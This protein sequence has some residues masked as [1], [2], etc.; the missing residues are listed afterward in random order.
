MDRPI[1]KTSGK[2]AF[3]DWFDFDKLRYFFKQE[4]FA[5]MTLAVLSFY[6]LFPN[7]FALGKVKCVVKDWKL[8]FFYIALVDGDKRL[9]F[10]EWTHG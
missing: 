2:E 3:I 4:T 6:V 10:C 9:V 8:Q 1:K 5:V 7:N